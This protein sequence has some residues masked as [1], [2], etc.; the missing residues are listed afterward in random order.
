MARGVKD[1]TRKDKNSKSDASCFRGQFQG[2]R[3]RDVRVEKVLSLPGAYEEEG[4]TR[5]SLPTSKIIRKS[6]IRNPERKR[7]S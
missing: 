2:L 5:E 7:G 4:V 1:V 3:A 6:G